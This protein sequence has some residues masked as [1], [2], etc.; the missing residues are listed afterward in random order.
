MAVSPSKFYCQ[1]LRQQMELSILT[2]HMSSYYETISRENVSSCDSLGVLCAARQKNGHWHRGVIQQLLSDNRVKVWFMDFGICQAVPSDGVLKLHPA[3]ISVPRFAFPCALSCLTDEDESVRHNQLEEF[4]KVLL[5][6]SAVYVHIDLFSAN[7]HLY[8]VTLRKNDAVVNTA[9]PSQENDV[10]PKCHPSLNV[11]VSCMGGDIIIPGTNPVFGHCVDRSTPQSEYSSYQKLSGFMCSPLTIPCRRSEM[12]IDSV[13]VAFL[14][15]VLNPSNFWIQNNDHLDDFEDLMKRISAVYDASETDDKILENPQPGQM[16]CARY[17]EDMH[18]Y[19]AVIIDVEDNSINV[20]FLDFGNTETVPLIDVRILLPEFQELPALAICCSLANAFPVCDVWTKRETDFFKTIVVDKQLTLHPIAKEENKYIVNVQCMNGTEQDDVL[21]LMVQAGYAEHWKMKQDPVLKII[22]GSQVQRSLPKYKKVEVKSV[23]QK[24]KVVIGVNA[25]QNRKSR[26]ILLMKEKHTVTSL[27][28][29]TVLSSKCG[30]ASGKFNKERH[31]KDY[32]FEPGTVLDVVCSHSASPGDFS[33]QIRSQ[34]PELDNLMEQIQFHYNTNK[35]PYENGQV[36]CVVKHSKDGKWYRGVVLNHL[37]QTEVEVLFVDYGNKETVFLRDLQAIFPDFLILESQAFRCCIG[38][39][40]E[41]LT[42]DPQNWNMEACHDFQ[43]FVESANAILTCTVSALVVRLPNHLYHVV[44]LLTPF[45]NLQQFLLERGHI[46]SCSFELTKSLAPSF[47]LRSFC[48][49]SFNIKIGSEE[50]MCITH[51][52]S[53]TKIFCQLSRNAS[54]LDKIWQK[55]AE[56]S[57]I[58]AQPNQTNTLCLAKYVDDGLFYRALV[59]SAGSLDYCLAYFVDF[60]NKELVRKNELLPIPDQASELLFTPMQAI[61][62][63]L[64][65]LKDTEIPVEVNT[66]FEKN[67]LGKQLKAVIVAKE[68]DGWFGVE[69]SDGDL[70]INK[71]IKELIKSR[72]C[73]NKS[74]VTQKC[75]EKSTRDFLPE[76]KNADKMKVKN[77]VIEQERERKKVKPFNQSGDKLHAEY[78]KEIVDLQKQRS[79]PAKLPAAKENRCTFLQNIQGQKYQSSYGEWSTEP[80]DYP[81]MQSKELLANNATASHVLKLNSSGQERNRRVKQK[82]MCLRQPNIEPHSKALGYISCINSLSDFYIHCADDENKIVQLADKLNGGTLVIKPETDGEIEEGDI[83]LAE[84]EYDCCIYRA[85]VREV[86]SEKSFE[87]EFIDYGNR[88]TVN[89]SKIYK[90]GKIFLNIPRLSIHCFL[91]RA[92]CE[93]PEKDWS[94]DTTAYFVS[95][96]NNQPVIFEFLQQHGEQWEVDIFCQ[97]I[98]VVNEL[99]QKE[100]SLG[101]QRKLVL[102]L[103][104]IRKPLPRTDADTDSNSQN[105]KLK[106]QNATESHPKVARQNVKPGQLELSEIAHVSREGHFYVKLSKNEQILSDLNMMVAQEAEKN[107]FLEVENIEEGLEYLTKSKATLQWHRSEI[108][109]KYVNEESMLVFFMD[110]GKFEVVSL[111]DTQLMSDKIRSIPRNTVLCKWICIRNLSG[112]PFERVAEIIKCHKIKI[113]FLRWLESAFIWEVEI[114]ID[115]IMLSEFWK[116][117]PLL[118]SLESCNL[119]DNLQ[120]D[121][122]VQLKQSSVSWA[123][124]QINKEYPVFVTSVTDPSDFF[125]QLEDSFEALKTLFKLLSNLPENLPPV[126]HE[127]IVPGACSLIKTGA[128]TKWSR[129]EVSEVSR[130]SGQ[131]T[132]TLIDLGISATIP[133][134]DSHKLKVIPEKLI[135]LP[136]LTYP[137]SLSRVSP[138]GGECWSNE[139]KLKVQE[140]LGKQGLTFR[141]KRYHP[142]PKLEVDVF[143]GPKNVAEV[144]VA[145]GCAVYSESASSLGSISSAERG[146][147]NSQNCCEPPKICCQTKSAARV[148]WLSGEE[149]QPQELDLLFKGICSRGSR[150]SSKSLSLRKKDRQKTF[151]WSSRRNNGHLKCDPSLFGQF[152]ATGTIGKTCPTNVLSEVLCEMQALYQQ[153]TETDTLSELT[154]KVDGMQISEESNT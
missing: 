143:C 113:L 17:Y 67:Y 8:Y 22:R 110:L 45:T 89:A 131:L 87:V 64:A 145:S 111:R 121:G 147:P 130:I 114:L 136:R 116:Q 39:V 37:S 141:F 6:Q 90:M 124:F 84:Y 81:T 77:Q 101:L 51:I 138:A 4:K 52:G 80:A 153:T 5:R 57:Q 55:I 149:E 154:T 61:K 65:D 27:Q 56:I 91:S 132:L 128:N 2:A 68:Y 120:V 11:T 107:S 129:V 73:D 30:K 48:Y 50:E 134:S 1:L 54:D 19:R 106:N 47:S 86:K 71:K 95:K 21:M 148:A 140:F 23:T 7:E 125:V 62:C 18:F 14:A 72:K 79:R 43:H 26:N 103:D 32:Q 70:R 122:R 133:I 53:P 146:L 123:L 33:C 20:C 142:K 60:G 105:K 13:C 66:W 139:A 119:S 35:T 46:Q 24:S 99:M 25:G 42:F 85:I 96:V 94:S 102:N 40:T 92:K 29:E 28:W 126:P 3:F 150:Q 127:L 49:S 76:V 83:V 82:Y 74:E 93:F 97:G 137:C 16:C 108:I 100:V 41:S 9:C 104:Q 151:L 98:S 59:S 44:D 36:A 112:L 117:S 109:K 118:Q 152:Q 75:A 10:I 58:P 31:Y 12:K 115:E 88:S 34:L 135:T 15:Y 78:G 144:L 63:Y 69:L 38:S